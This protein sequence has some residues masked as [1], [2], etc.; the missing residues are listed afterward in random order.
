MKKKALFSSILSIVLCLTM[1]S[2]ATF[3]LFTDSETVNIAVTAGTVDIDVTVENV[4]VKSYDKAWAPA[5]ATEDGAVGAFTNGGAATVK[6]NKVLIDKITPGDGVR[7]ELVVT[8]NSDIEIE[9]FTKLGLVDGV[10]LFKGMEMYIDGESTPYTGI[11]RAS[12]WKHLTTR[13]TGEVAR[14]AVELELPYLSTSQND[15]MGEEM[16]MY[17]TVQAVQGN[18]SSAD[19]EAVK[20]GYTHLYNVTDLQLF[21]ENVNIGNAYEDQ[22]VVLMDNIDLAGINWAPIGNVTFDRAGDGSYEVKAAFKGTFDG[23]NYKI[24]NLTI[25]NPEANGVALFGAVDN[26]T[27]KNIKVENVDITADGTAA[28]IV[29]YCINYSKPSTIENCHVSGDISIVADWAYVGGIAAYGHANISKCSVIDTTTEKGAITSENRNAVGGI[30]G[31]NYGS[32]VTD[33]VV[34]NLDL[35]AWSGVAGVEG[36]VP[37]AH[38]VSGCTVENVTLTKTRADGV[39]AVG[40]LVGSW[41]YSSATTITLSNNSAK[42][43]TLNGTH[44]PYTAYNE[45]YGASYNGTTNT[46]FTLDNN[47]ATNI[48]NNLVEV[49]TA[50]PETIQNMIDNAA[51][52]DTIV[53]QAGAYKTTINMRSDITLLGNTGAVVDCINLNGAGNVTFKNLVFDAA[54]VKYSYNGKGNS[55]QPANIISRVSGSK[56][57]GAANI[58]IDGCTFGGTFADGGACIAFTDQGTTGYSNITVK[59]CTFE[60]KNRIYDVYA[61]Y[62]GD[63][64]YFNIEGNTFA[65]EE[66]VNVPAGIK[67]YNI[68]LG[69]YQSGTPVVVKNNTFKTAATFADAAYI[70][71]HSNYG[72]SFDA[73]NCTGNTFAV[74]STVDLQAAINSAKNGDTIYLTAGVAYEGVELKGAIAENL[75]IVG[76]EGAIV[77]GIHGAHTASQLK[78]DHL[79]RY[80]LDFQGMGLYFDVN[81]T[82]WNEVRNVTMTG[83]TFVGTGTADSAQGNRLFDVGSDSPGSNQYFNIVIE[84][85]T[86]EN[87]IQGMRL[88]GLA[89]NGNVVRG[90]TIKN[91]GHNAIT[92]RNVA[93]SGVVLVEGNNITNAG[94]RALR[95][96]TNS[97]IVNYKNNKIVNSGDADGS[98]FK[99]NTLGTVTFEGNTVD[100]AAWNPLA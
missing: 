17:F 73:A 59:D 100:G 48:T 47:T 21:A 71:D 80:K 76:A 56:V 90:N 92:L 36:Y 74:K 6:G 93:A 24:S 4:E 83:C 78:I 42:T 60:A 37:G 26:A 11:T 3:A 19:K 20:A 18:A 89:G 69:R 1:I 14:V 45:L 40:L 79:T 43:A 98:N 31:W 75:T 54:G 5:T 12:G 88:G 41:S 39:P 99:A 25:N 8:N 95:I 13:E 9:F 49:K 32:T 7:F 81:G 91:V 96:G 51:A 46:N 85:C 87:A 35:T 84:N 86:V 61:Y 44:V 82:P 15:L 34:K 28:A 77:K 27:V 57:N 10:K 33:C 53:L 16:E 58:M 70:Q 29:G 72:V 22:T 68:Y 66:Y 63:N 62:S 65:S 2:G 38:T 97:G 30:M 23:Q 67:I 52:G 50:T 55:T 64:G 94:D